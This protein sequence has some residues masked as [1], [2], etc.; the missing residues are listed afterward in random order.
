M[1]RWQTHH[2]QNHVPDVSRMVSQRLIHTHSL[3]WHNICCNAQY[4]FLYE[5]FIVVSYAPN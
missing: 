1:T 5:F 4:V 2:S 3:R